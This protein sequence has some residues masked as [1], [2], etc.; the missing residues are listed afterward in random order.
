[1]NE[2]SYNYNN[3]SN[4]VKQN[5]VISNHKWIDLHDHED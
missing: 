1:M 2:W 5:K 3:V 4:K